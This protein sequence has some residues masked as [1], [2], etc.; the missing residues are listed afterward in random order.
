MHCDVYSTFRSKM[1]MKL[2]IIGREKYLYGSYTTCK[3]T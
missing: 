1:Y 3:V 2:Q